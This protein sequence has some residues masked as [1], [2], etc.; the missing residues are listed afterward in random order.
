V[1]PD[2]DPSRNAG[3][4]KTLLS[5]PVIKK[6]LKERKN[7]EQKQ[8]K[9]R[10]KKKVPAGFDGGSCGLSDFFGGRTREQ[11]RRKGSKG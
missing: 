11:E 8:K 9:T 1:P 4:Q 7:I 2:P 5:R 10:G 6:K 3:W